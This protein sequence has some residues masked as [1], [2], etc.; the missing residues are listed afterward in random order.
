MKYLVILLILLV[1]FI[2]GCITSEDTGTFEKA[3]IDACINIC[4][5]IKDKQDLSN[6][7]CIGDPIPEH[8]GWVCDVAHDP[9]EP[10]DNLPENQCRS[11]RE[12]RTKHFIEV[13]PNCNFIRA[14]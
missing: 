14:I 1:I 10:I 6:G 11:Y 12:G 4:N 3:A 13:D 7:P 2:G 5:S 8:P 9:R